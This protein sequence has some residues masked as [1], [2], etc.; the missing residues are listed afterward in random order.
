MVGGVWFLR[1]S[2]T[3]ES[4]L[5]G[6]NDSRS[7]GGAMTESAWYVLQTRRH[8]EQLAQCKLGERALPTYLPRILQWPRPAVGSDIAPMFPTYLFVHLTLSNDFSRV[9]WT[10]GVKC[11]VAFGDGPVPSDDAAVDFLKQREGPDGLIRCADPLAKDSEVR[12][13]NGPFRGLTAVVEERLPAHERVRVLM[14]ILA[15]QTSVELP[16]KWLRR[17]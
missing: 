4:Q 6:K 2:D 12:I 1:W 7:S 8:K 3:E 15:R 17:A 14:H 11:F 10:P 9:S 13:I 5:T 16:E